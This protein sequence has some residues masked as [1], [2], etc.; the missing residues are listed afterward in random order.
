MVVDVFNW[1]F[2]LLSTDRPG[3]RPWAPAP[4]AGAKSGRGP[5]ILTY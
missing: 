5:G 3:P 4:P 1:N 2:M